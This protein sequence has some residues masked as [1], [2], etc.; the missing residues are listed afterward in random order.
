VPELEQQYQRIVEE[1]RRITALNEAPD[2]RP[3]G[4]PRH[5]PEEWSKRTTNFTLHWT[6]CRRFSLVSMATPLA[7]APGQ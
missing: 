5:D 2:V 3:L 1:N 7:V 6:G 4:P